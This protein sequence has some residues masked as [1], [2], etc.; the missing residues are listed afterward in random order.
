MKSLFLKT[1]WNSL[2]GYPGFLKKVLSELLSFEMYA[3]AFYG[4]FI[5][6]M[7]PP[8]E[9]FKYST[10]YFFFLFLYPASLFVVIGSHYNYFARKYKSKFNCVTEE[11]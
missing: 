11:K 8:T 1:F 6:A 10:D 3:I 4:T 5:F 7:T 2:I 9:I